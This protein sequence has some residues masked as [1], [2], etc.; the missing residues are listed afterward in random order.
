[1]CL[2]KIFVTM[3]FEIHT[4]NTKIINN[5][6]LTVCAFPQRPHSGQNLLLICP[7]LFISTTFFIYSF[8]VSVCISRITV[9]PVL[10]RWGMLLLSGPTEEDYSKS[11]HVRSFTEKLNSTVNFKTAYKHQICIFMLLFFL[12]Y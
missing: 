9:I 7:V 5:G 11:C 3:W 1:M 4:R 10:C 6:V 2:A 8:L 12:V